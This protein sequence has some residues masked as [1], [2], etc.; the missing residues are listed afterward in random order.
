MKDNLKG[1]LKKAEVQ[2]DNCGK[3]F[4]IKKLKT[5]CIND[6]VQ[7]TYFVCPHC[8]REFT[9]YYSDKRIRKNIK[10]IEELQKKMAEIVEKNKE[11]MQE[12]REKYEA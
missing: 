8:K 3:M 5:K 4:N 12:L 10:D 7:R 1:S 2:C 11:I 6:D 9:A